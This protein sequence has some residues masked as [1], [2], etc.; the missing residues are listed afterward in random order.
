MGSGKELDKLLH[1]QYLF[2]FSQDGREMEGS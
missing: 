2:Y 1:F